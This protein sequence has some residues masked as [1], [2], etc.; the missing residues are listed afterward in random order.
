MD[1]HAQHGDMVTTRR[2]V[3]EPVRRVISVLLA[4]LA[5]WWFF[6]RPPLWELVFPPDPPRPTV[7][8]GRPPAATAP[9]GRAVLPPG[10]PTAAP[11]RVAPPAPPPAS[12]PLP[13]V[14]APAR[15]AQRPV[16]LTPAA[17][18]Q[19]AAAPEISAA[20]R[21]VP[22]MIAAARAQVGV[23]RG[24]DP[25][26]VRLDF[27]GGDVRRDSG[28]C[29][30]VVIRA[31]RDGAGID[32]QAATNRDMRAN[33]SRYPRRWG[34]SRP[35]PN[36]DHRRVPNLE[37]LFER[38][39]ARLPAGSADQPGDIVTV[40]LP[41]NLPHIMVLSDRRAAGGR[42]LVIHNVGRGTQEEDAR[43]RWPETGHYRLTEAARKRLTDLARR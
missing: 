17:V 36:I 34:L 10:P 6:G 3:P 37:T 16:T 2:A 28:V 39:G 9:A 31:L 5:A 26:Y 12:P 33:F 30:D 11:S 41:G 21:G 4:L 32:L 7:P 18:V 1:Q 35:D 43:A 27:P 24:Y 40:R 25:A 23:T 13:V 8:A 38:I 20:P 15:P 19:P 42:Y 14:P 22:A 29:S